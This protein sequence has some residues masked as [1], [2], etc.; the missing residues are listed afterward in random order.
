MLKVNEIFETIQGEGVHTGVPSIF[1]RLQ[2]CPIGCAWC[3]TK[4][5]WEVE[6]CDEVNL[7]HVANKNR[8]SSAWC[9]AS[10]SELVNYFKTNWTAKHVVITGGEPCLYDLSEVT[11]QLE[12]FGFTCQIETSGTFEIKV[13]DTTWVTVSPKVNMKGGFKVLRST[14]ERANEIKHPVGTEKDI[15][16]LKRILEEHCMRNDAV[17][18]LQPISQ[19]TRATELC[20]RHCILNNW[21]LSIQTHKYLQI[22]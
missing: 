13:S 6:T 11:T 12:S 1:L 10:T 5:T 7:R 18:A 20:I 9:S 2:G 16:N 19:K 15:E 14:I 8:D 21:R 22:A 17:V 3:D 4:H